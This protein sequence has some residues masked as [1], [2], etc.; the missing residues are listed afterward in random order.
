MLTTVSVQCCLSSSCC[1]S[2]YYIFVC[3]HPDLVASMLGGKAFKILR[4][5]EGVKAVDFRVSLKLDTAGDLVHQP[6]FLTLTKSNNL[7]YPFPNL[8][9]SFSGRVNAVRR[10][11]G[12]IARWNNVGCFQ[13]EEAIGPVCQ[14]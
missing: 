1:N 14:N 8:V 9:T 2:H 11:E 12:Q 7:R 5:F 10:M 4:D 3:L 13:V 6:I